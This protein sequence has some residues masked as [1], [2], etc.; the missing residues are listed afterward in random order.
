M[1]NALSPFVSFWIID[2]T[3]V[4]SEVSVEY[5]APPLECALEIRAAI[6]SGRSVREGALLFAQ[7][8]PCPFA[9]VIGRL[10]LRHDQGE[11]ATNLLRL[12]STPLQR[13]LF[14][15]ILRGSRGEPVG[16]PLNG[17]IDELRTASEVQMEEFAQTLPSRLMLPLLLLQ[18]PAFLILLLGPLLH[19]LSRSLVQ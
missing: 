9:E 14:M 4:S 5:L 12:A 2:A 10:I 8:C 1:F 16:T 6:Q 13:G 11:S 3:L 7:S 17:L 19:D 18:F 15:L